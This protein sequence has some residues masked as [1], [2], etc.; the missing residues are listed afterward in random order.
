MA[1]S[2]KSV[3]VTGGTGFIGS[4]TVTLLVQAGWHVT[5]VDNLAN[6]RCDISLL[7]GRT[8]PP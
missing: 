4:H 7:D 5:I 8:P 6:S 2:Q 3:L 1:E